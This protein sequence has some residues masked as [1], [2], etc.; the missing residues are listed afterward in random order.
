MVSKLKLPYIL[1]PNTCT[2]SLTVTISRKSETFAT[3]NKYVF[4]TDTSLPVQHIIHIRVF[5]S[6]CTFCGLTQMCNTHVYHYS[7]VWNTFT[8][9]FFNFSSTSSKYM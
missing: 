9:L 4:N 7:I 1:C 3:P 2:I 8:D 5:S 6:F